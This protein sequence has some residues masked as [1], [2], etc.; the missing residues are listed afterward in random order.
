MLIGP[1]KVINK[2]SPCSC[3]CK[4][5]DPWHKA[6]YRRVV[7]VRVKEGQTLGEAS[8]GTVSMP[9]STQPVRVVR[10][11]TLWWVDPSSIVYDK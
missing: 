3:G 10:K 5:Q 1:V 2:G 9:Y 11:H 4:G 6:S 8:E 7:H